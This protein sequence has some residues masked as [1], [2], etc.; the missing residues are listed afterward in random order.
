M[1]WRAGPAT[2]DELRQAAHT[3][4][5]VLWVHGVGFPLVMV[6]VLLVVLAEARA[7]R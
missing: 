4:P 2:R 3:T 1:R 5:E 6:V 7:G